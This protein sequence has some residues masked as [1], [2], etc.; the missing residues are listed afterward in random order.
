MRRKLKGYFTVEASFIMPLVLFLYLLIILATLFLYC[1]C[2][3][4][5]DNFLL[6]MR[7]GNFTWG[8]EQYGEVI[9]GEAE[10]SQWQAEDYVM[11]RLNYKKSF[12]PFFPSE[13]GEC[14]ING[15]NVLVQT[16]QKALRA[17]IAKN[18]QKL[19]PVKIIRGGRGEENARC[20]IL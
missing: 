10:K 6:G 19:N 11:E 17:M 13:G 16:R 2:V 7:A 12:Y 8:E 18:V 20:K 4:S 3:I 9:Y 5:Q 15:E 1:R 14:K